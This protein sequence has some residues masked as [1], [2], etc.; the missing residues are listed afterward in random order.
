MSPLF[1]SLFVFGVALEVCILWRLV[2]TSLW[3]QFPYFS[4]YVAYV[5]AA[6][7]FLYFV[8]TFRPAL[9]RALFWGD[10]IISIPLRFL[11]IWD[12]FRYTFPKG[13]A[14]YRTAY[15]GFM[16][17]ALALLVF[18]VGSFWSYETYTEFHVIIP[19]LDRSFGF[20]QAVMI[21]TILFAA[22]YFG[23]PL[24]RNLR[25]LAVGFGVYASL[26]TANNAMID[27]LKQRYMPYWTFISVTSFVLTLAIWAWAVWVEAPNPQVVPRI[28]PDM[29]E[30]Q[31]WTQGWDQTTASVRKAINP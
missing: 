27:L 5:F 17:V 18:A 6:T 21:L 24:G 2:R 11:V 1:Y 9:Y 31:R 30:L 25:G 8:Q 19:A 22:G 23:L 4:F 20:A 29:D 28:A 10:E 12:V 13:S 15:R 14:L 3:R 7:L 16:T 26:V